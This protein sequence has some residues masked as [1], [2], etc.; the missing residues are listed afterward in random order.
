MLYFNLSEC[1]NEDVAD[2]L[3]VKVKQWILKKMAELFRSWKKKLWKKLSED[4][5][6]VSIRGVFS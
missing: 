5:E 2:K 1:E 4:K 3:R 6:S